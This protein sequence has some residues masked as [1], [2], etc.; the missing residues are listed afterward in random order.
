M[1]NPLCLMEE[2]RK[3]HGAAL[4]PRQRGMITGDFSTNASPLTD[5]NLVW[6]PLHV[7]GL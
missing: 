2:V 1:E 7:K 6:Q 3:V 4:I 5:S